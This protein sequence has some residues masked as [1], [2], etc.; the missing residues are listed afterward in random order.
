VQPGALGMTAADGNGRCDCSCPL[1]IPAQVDGALK[2]LNSTMV[3]H[4]AVLSAGTVGTDSLLYLTVKLWTAKRRN[5]PPGTAAFR[6]QYAIQCCVSY[7]VK[8]LCSKFCRQRR[9]RLQGV[10]VMRTVN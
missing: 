9:A 3:N 5:C 2:V 1:V 10:C 6:G 8:Y 4:P 7:R